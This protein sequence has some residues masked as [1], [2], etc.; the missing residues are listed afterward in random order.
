MRR[1]TTS[2][3]RPDG[4]VDSGDDWDT[5]SDALR[6]EERAAAKLVR[7]H[8]GRLYACAYR[9][10]GDAG[11]AEEIVQD[12]FDQ[13]F[14]RGAEL[15]RES[16]LSTWLYVVVLNRCRDTLRRPPFANA[17]SVQPLDNHMADH[18]P[19]PHERAERLDRDE[20]LRRALGTL[21]SDLREVIALRYASGLSYQEIATLQGCAAGTVASR[22]HRALERLGATLEA[23]GFTRENA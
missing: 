15:R 12:A 3:A 1:N 2:S 9:V 14:R 7:R 21:P 22:L 18:S 16:A 4:P 8:G 13:L 11:A 10:V 6:G 5:L 17:R 19:T 23:R 20:R